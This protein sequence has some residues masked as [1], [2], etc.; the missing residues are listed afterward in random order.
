MI[1]YFHYLLDESWSGKLYR[2]CILYPFLSILTGDTFLDVGCGIG[3][4]LSRG[5]RHTSMGIDV[6]AK[7]VAF[8]RSKGLNVLHFEPEAPF[9][10][11]TS[12]FPVVICDQVI[13]HLSTPDHTLSEI[14]RV[15]TPG[16]R[17]V[18]GVPCLKGFN[19]DSDHK[20]FYSHSNLLPILSKYSFTL[21][22]YFYFP[23]PLPFFGRLFTF[24]YQYFICTSCKPV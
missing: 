5:N 21:H 17:F 6:N 14:F 19:A 7:A 23:L 4:M 10:L 22:S 24:Q 3:R 20:T 2:T 11:Q 13:E 12:S 16:G 9:P 8:C 15:L 1:S 18:L